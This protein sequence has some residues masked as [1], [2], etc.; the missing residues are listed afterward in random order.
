MRRPR[1]QAAVEKRDAPAGSDL[2]HSHQA[3]LRPSQ[4]TRVHPV[5]SADSVRA[6]LMARFAGNYPKLNGVRVEIAKIKVGTDHHIF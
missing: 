4:S 5:E 2:E 1:E 3:P 6:E